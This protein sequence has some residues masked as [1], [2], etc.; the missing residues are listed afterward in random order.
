MKFWSGVGA[1]VRLCSDSG[2]AD[3]EGPGT[4]VRALLFQQVATS[5]A[6]QELYFHPL[7]KHAYC[8]HEVCFGRRILH[9]VF[10]LTTGN[11][12]ESPTL[13]KNL[14]RGLPWASECPGA[15]AQSKVTRKTAVPVTFDTI[16]SPRM[17][18]I[19]LTLMGLGLGARTNC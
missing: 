7:W 4:I 6:F 9:T 15:N 18:G 17:V 11:A 12:D 16:L 3:G 2:P 10:S 19:G 1:G 8:L 13:S 5:Q 14:S